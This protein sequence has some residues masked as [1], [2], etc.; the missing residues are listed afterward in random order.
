V[1][2]TTLKYFAPFFHYL[3]RVKHL[4]VENRS[5]MAGARRKA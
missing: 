5:W 4:T 3:V 1:A 2:D